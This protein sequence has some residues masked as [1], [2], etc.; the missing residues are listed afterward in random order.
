MDRVREVKD[1]HLVDV[2]MQISKRQIDSLMEGVE[3]QA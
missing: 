3:G 2:E 1:A